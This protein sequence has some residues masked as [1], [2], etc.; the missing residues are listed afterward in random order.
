M[1]I[2]T[3]KLGQDEVLEYLYEKWSDPINFLTITDA[4]GNTLLHTA[5]ANCNVKTFTVVL[6][7]ANEMI[8]FHNTTV[9]EKGESIISF[10]WPRM[11][12]NSFIN[13]YKALLKFLYTYAY[14]HI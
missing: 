1:I 6:E 10:V 9:A 8:S 7:K 4:G 3:V 13:S 12:Q 5:V 11:I 14:I 2:L